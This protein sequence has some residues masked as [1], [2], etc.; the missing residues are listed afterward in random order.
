VTTGIG[1]VVSESLQVDAAFDYS[2]TVKTLSL[3]AV[4]M[5]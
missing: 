2:R 4:L 3:S 5:R 1:F